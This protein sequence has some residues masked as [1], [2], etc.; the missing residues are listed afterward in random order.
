MIQKTKKELKL[1]VETKTLN[2][3]NER[4]GVTKRLN[5]KIQ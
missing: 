3:N 4:S 5:Q 1:K 2:Q